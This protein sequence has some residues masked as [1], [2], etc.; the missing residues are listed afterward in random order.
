M[1][2]LASG[3]FYWFYTTNLQANPVFRPSDSL[4]R[5]L[6]INLRLLRL[7]SKGPSPGSSDWPQRDPSMGTD[8]NNTDLHKEAISSNL[9]A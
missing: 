6:Q 5:D 9:S 8:Q 1:S 3:C 4:Q 7:I 2:P